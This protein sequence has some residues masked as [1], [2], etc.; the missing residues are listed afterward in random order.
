[1]QHMKITIK[2]TGLELTQ[3]LRDYIENRLW[4]LNKFVDKWDLEGAVVANVEVEKTTFHHQKGDIYRAEIN[5]QLPGQLL[6][7]EAENKDIR[8]AID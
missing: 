7:A 6:R 5:L 8:A 3:P 4:S 1:M 2:S